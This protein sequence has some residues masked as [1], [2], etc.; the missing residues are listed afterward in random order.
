MLPWQSLLMTCYAAPMYGFNALILP[1]NDVFSPGNVNDGWP[2]AIV[3][4]TVLLTAGFGGLL[5]HWLLSLS[6][7]RRRLIVILNVL[8]PFIFGLGATACHLQW[9]WLLIIGFALPAGLVFANLFMLCTVYL[10]G[11]GTTVGRVGFSTGVY[12]IYFGIWGA[13]YSVV[14]PIGLASLGLLWILVIT[15]ISLAGIQLLPLLLMKDPPPASGS[16]AASSGDRGSDHKRPSL[17]YRDVL[18][19]PSFWIYALFFFLFLAPGFG[20]KIIV[21]ALTAQVFHV[22]QTTGAIIAASFL[23][24]YGISRLGFGI[25]SDKL[26]IKPMYLLFSAV[27]VVALL[28]SAILLPHLNGVVLFTILLCITGAMFA[29]GKCLWSVVM[30]RIYGPENFKTPLAMTQAF[31]GLAGFAGPITLTWAL[32]SQDVVLSTTYWL[33]A[34]AAALFICIVLFH[35]LRRVDYTKLEH[36]E[37]QGFQ[38]TLKSRNEFDRF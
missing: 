25:L 7:G 12:G 1:I 11:W 31:Y 20:F 16:L 37:R 3:G 24:S 21:T 34:A 15:G 13:V 26:R 18:K 23:I 22:G 27:Q 2:G 19:I 35:M 4:G 17:T 32:R 14:A 6:G 10:V 36:H 5:H 29:A 30:V 33:Y 38:W 28:S 8:I 9:F